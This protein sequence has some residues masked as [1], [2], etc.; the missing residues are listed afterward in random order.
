MESIGAKFQSAREAKGY[1][2]EQVARE[3][4][5]SKRF[6]QALE[7]ED[8]EVVPGETYLIGFLRS[9]AEFLDL[10]PREAVS[11]YKNMKL[12]EQPA[13]IDELLVKKSPKPLILA[14]VIVI[15]LA[16][17]I[18]GGVLFF[19]SDFFQSRRVEAE[20]TP[21]SG[22]EYPMV[23]EV[24]EQRFLQGD[25][26]RIPVRDGEY[27]LL[28]AQIGQTVAIDT[29]AGRHTLAPQQEHAIDI[30]EDGRVDIL[31]TVREIA[32]SD[33]PASAV[34]RFDRG[35]QLPAAAADGPTAADGSPTRTEP[36]GSTTVAA[37]ERSSIVIGE[38][39]RRSPITLQFQFTAPT[40][41]REVIDEAQRNEQFF[42]SGQQHTSTAQDRA[43][44]WLSNAGATRLTVEGRELSLGG[45]GQVTAFLIGWV[46][47]PG[48]MRLE[49]VP[50]Y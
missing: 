18:T 46:Q 45:P 17:V 38:F 9:Y 6:L 4:H 31:I 19:T 27:P 50:V 44:I 49:M 25:T 14:A 24:L 7:E 15:A 16:G 35:V 2:L 8:F 37:R 40:M 39:P 13:P 30:T 12:Q 5:I 48:N 26:I 34:L 28:L 20:A 29:P 10:D 42:T 3:T 41:L 23:D 32:A 21:V 1:S 22:Q 43:K 36:V 33:S 11:L 47:G